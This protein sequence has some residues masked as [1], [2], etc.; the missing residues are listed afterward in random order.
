VS[1]DAK[2][3]NIRTLK[4]DANLYP[5]DI[6]HEYEVTSALRSEQQCWEILFG[7]FIAWLRAEAA[8]RVAY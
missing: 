4:V 2:N 6:C 5:R 7:L 1:M 3:Y 8:H